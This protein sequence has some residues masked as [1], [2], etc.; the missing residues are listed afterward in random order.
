MAQDAE[1]A[2]IYRISDPGYSGRAKRKIRIAYSIGI[3][4]E[5]SWEV[6][7]LFPE[8]FLYHRKLRPNVPMIQKMFYAG[9]QI[10]WGEEY[11]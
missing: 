4:T 3:S 7:R 8:F 10:F 5:D 11:I 9:C 1:N 2:G 6:E